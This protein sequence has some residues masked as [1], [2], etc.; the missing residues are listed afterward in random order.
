MYA[1]GLA[2]ALGAGIKDGSV[3]SFL[4][5]IGLMAV[6]EGGIRWYIQTEPFG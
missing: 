2:C 3:G 1:G 6:M 4:I 5:V